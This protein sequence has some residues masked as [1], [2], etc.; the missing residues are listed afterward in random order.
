VKKP[1]GTMLAGETSPMIE[2]GFDG[3]AGPEP[4]GMFLVRVE[5]ENIFNVWGTSQWTVKDAIVSRLSLRP[6]DV[7][8]KPTI[9][10]TK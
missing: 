7:K 4:T 2:A 9:L 3:W 6:C 8:I 1:I 5:F 10:S